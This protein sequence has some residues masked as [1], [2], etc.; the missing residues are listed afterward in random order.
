MFTALRG[1]HRLIQKKHVADLK[2][3]DLSSVLTIL[4]EEILETEQAEP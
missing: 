3:L 4:Y 2:P 1:I